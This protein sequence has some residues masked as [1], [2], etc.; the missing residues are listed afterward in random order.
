MNRVLVAQAAAGLAAYVLERRRTATGR[1]PTVVIG[2]DGR[3][4]S[5]R[6]R[7]GLRR[8]LRGCRAA[9]DPAP[10]PAADAGAR[11][12][13]A[14]ARR[15]CRRHGDRE[16]QPA[17]RQR[18]QGLPR[19]RRRR[20]ADR[21]ARRR[22]D[23]RAHPAD[24]R[25]RRRRRPPALARLRDGA[26]VARRRVHRGDG[27]RRPRARRRA[28]ASPGSTP[29]CT[30]SGGR[31]S[32]ASSM[33]PATPRPCRSTRSSTPTAR[34]RRSPSRTPR[35]RA[36]W[37]SRSRRARS[38]DADLVIAN[39]PDA[40]RLAVAV[41]DPHAA[42]GWRRLTGNQIGLLLGWRAARLGRESGRRRPAHRSPARWSP[43]RA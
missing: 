22:R 5:R 25:R 30:A 29:R 20:R 36:R 28:R 43:H 1:T 27:G 32:R 15:G 2:Y 26:R 8:A 24:R 3:R 23:R 17:E 4:N 31:R 6:V 11:V 19:R 21:L 7:P 16:P 13:G 12:R 40:D 33:S 34:S 38:V 9:R 14:P 18:L 39:D 42:G 10:A 35:S 41:P 37:T